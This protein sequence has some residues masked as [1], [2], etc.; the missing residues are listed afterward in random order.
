MMIP[1]A[2]LRV[3]GC[4]ATREETATEKKNQYPLAL[5]AVNHGCMR[6]LVVV[7]GFPPRRWSVGVK[8]AGG[9]RV[10]ELYGVQRIGQRTTV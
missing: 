3:V 10:C 1:A 4:L 2:W 5:Q 7:E 8:G 6:M 9:G